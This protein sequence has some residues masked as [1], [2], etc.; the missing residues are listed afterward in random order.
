M[1]VFDFRVYQKE[2]RSL[3]SYILNPDRAANR[4]VSKS[5]YVLMDDTYNKTTII[6]SYLDW[7]ANEHEFQVFDDGRKALLIAYRNGN[8]NITDPAGVVVTEKLRDNCLLEIDIATAATDFEW[9]PS[10]HGFGLDDSVGNYGEDYMWVARD[11]T[12]VPH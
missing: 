7:G 1:N 5:A 8:V 9:C 2:N 6:P 4:S 3:L 10:D 11:V 12:E